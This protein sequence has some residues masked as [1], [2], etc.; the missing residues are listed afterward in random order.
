M[1]DFEKE[2]LHHFISD[3]LFRVKEDIDEE[4]KAVPLEQ[5][6]TKELIDTPKG[7]EDQKELLIIT[8]E[9]SPEESETLNKIIG[10]VGLTNDQISIESDSSQTE[11]HHKHLNFEV[12]ANTNTELYKVIKQDY[13]EIMA[14]PPLSQ[15]HRDREEKLKLWNALK[16]WFNLS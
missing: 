16:E 6:H 1:I 11:G 9:L 13:A 3:Q 12:D 8:Q 14:C 10:A 15:I 7:K 2:N 5:E 4:N